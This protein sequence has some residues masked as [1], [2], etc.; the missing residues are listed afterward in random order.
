MQFEKNYKAAVFQLPP[1]CCAVRYL[2]LSP[3]PVHT[4]LTCVGSEQPEWVLVNELTG[5]FLG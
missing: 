1:F 2:I 4:V 3:F 5:L